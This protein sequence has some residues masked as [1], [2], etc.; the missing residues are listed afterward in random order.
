MSCLENKIDWWIPPR[1]TIWVTIIMT[2]HSLDFLGTSDSLGDRIQG[3]CKIFLFTDSARVNIL[4]KSVAV[5][6]CI[7]WHRP[8]VIFHPLL[9]GKSTMFERIIRF[10]KRRRCFICGVH[11]LEHVSSWLDVIVGVNYWPFHSHMLRWKVWIKLVSFTLLEEVIPYC[12]S[13]SFTFIPVPVMSSVFVFI[14]WWIVSSLTSVSV[15][16][17]VAHLK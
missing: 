1:R 5:E 9:V 6:C 3:L 4:L 11:L 7:W 12:L 14:C 16:E 17:N 2:Q 10:M 15:D 13:E 8:S